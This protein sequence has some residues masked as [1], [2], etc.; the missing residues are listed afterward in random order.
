MV[1]HWQSRTMATFSSGLMFD[2]L[3]FQV[4]TDAGL[5]HAAHALSHFYEVTQMKGDGEAS[6]AVPER[7][8]C[9]LWYLGQG[10]LRPKVLQDSGHVAA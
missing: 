6:C 1:G 2:D 10:R 3:T 4:G 9:R 5:R 8:V 7:R